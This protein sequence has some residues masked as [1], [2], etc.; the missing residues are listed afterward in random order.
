MPCT[1]L[2][3]T[4]VS[5][6][7]MRTLVAK[8]TAFVLS[9]SN[10]ILNQKNWCVQSALKHRSR[11]VSK[12]AKLTVQI[13]STSNVSFAATLP[14]GSAGETPTFVRAATRGNAKEITSVNY[15]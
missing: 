2:P 9:K 13:T 12:V 8:R 6:A 1:N 11:A 5:N 4:S 7:K 3:I 10:K 15:R 14:N